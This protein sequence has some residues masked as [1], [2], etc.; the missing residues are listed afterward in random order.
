MQHLAAAGF[1]G[2]KLSAV[3]TWHNVGQ[4][5]ELKALADTYGAQ[6]RLIR[7]RPSGPATPTRSPALV[8]NPARTST[9]CWTQHTQR[10]G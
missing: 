4:F 10:K 1:T 7:L 3:V 5:D 9:T 6:L 8:L 2:F